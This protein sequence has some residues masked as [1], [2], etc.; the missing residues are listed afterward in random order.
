MSE[1][2][3]IYSN[4]K[5]QVTLESLVMSRSFLSLSDPDYEAPTPEQ[6]KFLRLYIGLSQAK[7]GRLLGKRVTC[8]GCS[9]VR[10]WETKRDS[11][12][13]RVIDANAWRRMLY[14]ANLVSPLDD[15]KL[16]K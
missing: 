9:I 14:A 1:N 15:V 6:V 13:Y 11:D 5:S 7:L 2:K 3:E 4:F 16:V 8:R 10:K 12:E